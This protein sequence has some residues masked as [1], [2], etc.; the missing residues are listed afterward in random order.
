M[1]IRRISFLVSNFSET[2]LLKSLIYL[3]KPISGV[4][5]SNRNSS[6]FKRTAI[7]SRMLFNH[8]QFMCSAATNECKTED[9]YI[10]ISTI[11]N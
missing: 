3:N 8:V 9:H 1:N 10:S 4:N 7:C 6:I 2:Q 5:K 11:I